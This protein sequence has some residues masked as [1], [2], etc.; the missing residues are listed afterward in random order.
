[1]SDMVALLMDDPASSARTAGLWFLST[2]TWVAF[3]YTVVL[4]VIMTVFVFLSSLLLGRSR[5][6]KREGRT[7]EVRGSALPVGVS[8]IM[9]AYNEEMGILDSVR[10]MLQLSYPLFEVVVV[11]DGSSDTTLSLLVEE[12]DLYPVEMGESPFPELTTN[13]VRAVFVPSDPSVPLRVVDKL[14]GGNKAFAVNVGISAAVHPWVMVVDADSLADVDALTHAMAEV[15]SSSSPVLGVGGTVLPS[16]DSVIVDGVVQEVRAPRR[17]LALL[18][19]SEY[20]RSFVVGR[21]AF[22]SIRSVA[23]ISGAF[24]VFRRSDLMRVGGYTPGHMGE[25]LDLTVRLQRHS[26]DDGAGPVLVHVPECLLWTEVPETLSVLAKQR[27]RWHQGLRQTMHDHVVTVGN[28]QFGRF[29]KYGMSYLMFFEFLAPLVE[30]AGY[31]ALVLALVFMALD[32]MV[33]LLLLGTTLLAGFL[34]TAL[35]IWVEQRHLG[36]Y[37]HRSDLLRL[38]LA[39]LLEQFGYRQLTVYWRIRAQFSRSVS[40]GEMVRRGHA[41]TP[42]L[43][44]V[45]HSNISSILP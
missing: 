27:T 26:A 24:G 2:W 33:A 44:P 28:P 18:Q 38:L 16:N 15:Y 4:Q 8:A 30:G 41:G 40:W 43:S 39:A 29:G 42:N 13:P 25:D 14:P 6:A 17:L 21:V 22:G 36:L 12:F 1:M 23:M 7:M 34:N 37:T 10:A 19:L 31:L 9:P 45:E 32:P 5:P 11:N 20:L 3:I 35:A